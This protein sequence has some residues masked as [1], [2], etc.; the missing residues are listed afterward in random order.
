MIDFSFV[1]TPFSKRVRQTLLCG[2]LILPLAGCD[3]TMNTLKADR[4]H[5]MEIQDY[6]DAMAPRQ[7]DAEDASESGNA[8]PSFQPYVS[9]TIAGAKPSPLVSISVNQNVPL[10]DVLYQLAEQADYDLELDPA[11][12]G[13]I[14]FTARERPFD[15]VIERIADIAGLRYKFNDDVLRVEVDTPYNKTYKIDYLN[16]IRSNTGSV[17]NNVAVVSGDGAA[18]T[19]ST[20][21]ASAES[22][23]DFWGELGANIQQILGNAANRSLR[24][25][26]DPRITATAANPQL[27]PVA[28]AAGQDG[29]IVVAPPD[30]DLQVGTLPVEDDTAASG[31]NANASGAS[32]SAFSFSMNKQAGMITAFASDR[33]HKELGKYLADIR[34]SVTAQVLIEAKIL[35]VSLKDQFA[36]GIDWNVI[37]ALGGEGYMRFTGPVTGGTLLNP[38]NIVSNRPTIDISGSSSATNSNLFAAFIGNDIQALVNAIQG[39]GTVKAL[40]SPRLTVLNNQSAV[41]NV[42]T[43]QVFF[44]IDIDRTEGTDGQG[45]TIEI[46]SEIRNVPEGVLVNVIPSINLDDATVSLALRPTITRVVNRVQDP[47]VQFVSTDIVSLVPELNVQEIDSVIKVNSGQAIVMGG[48]LQDRI[49]TTSENV[50]IVGEVPVVGNLFKKRGD[51]ISK[52]E[53]VILL[54]ATIIEGGDNVHNTDKD[55]YRTFS[56]DRRPFAL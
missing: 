45:D 3:M 52:T 11:I 8:I 53:L 19:G 42:A 49:E 36:A 1:K 32:D 54:K 18:D 5:D 43:N 35:E 50:P 25:N 12:H 17:R 55:L 56:Q 14:I 15:Q 40:A 29:N 10:R 33:A 44:E 22:E 26:R 27:R 34:K 20:F 9:E 31:R 23:A 48:L 46:D 7:A 13:A 41:M 4:G 6:R 2:L 38:E 21:Q 24:T 39:F 28:P 47:A 51:S 37:G 30:V 16:Y